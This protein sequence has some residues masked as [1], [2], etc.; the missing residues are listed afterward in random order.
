LSAV[1]LALLIAACSQ[2]PQGVAPPD[3]EPQF[4]TPG[5][6]T[7]FRLAAS[8]E[9]IYVAGGWNDK[10]AL[11]KFTRTGRLPW[12]RTLT[13]SAGDASSYVIDVASGTAG[14][15]YVLYASEREEYNGGED[16]TTIRR[17]YLRKYAPDKRLVWQRQ[18]TSVPAGSRIET[19]TS[20]RSGNLYLALGWTYPEA[21]GELR[22]YSAGGTLL[23]REATADYARD[24]VV[25]S[26]GLVYSLEGDFET[27][28]RSTLTKYSSRGTV[29]WSKTLPVGG[30]HL[31]LGRDFEV[32]VGG[33][34]E[35]EREILLLAKYNSRGVKLWQKVVRKD[36]FVRLGGLG[37]DEQGNVYAAIT[38]REDPYGEDNIYLYKYL[39]TGHRTY[40]RLLN[41]L[42]DRE[43]EPS[44]NDL[45]V[46]NPEEVYLG[47]GSSESDGFLIR[48][49][50]RNG[51][52]TWVR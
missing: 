30:S 36:F 24:L 40:V 16:T 7:A 48:M 14:H 27:F 46:L 41:A 34:V 15:A 23:W 12:I 11:L 38:D 43:G 8:S 5:I 25:S 26:T 35:A 10:A 3:L 50:G 21:A 33:E 19:L 1:L 51:N 22:K 45:V 29:I 44:L 2:T 37:A 13:P 32:Y 42:A 31:S 9:G 4:G 39:P 28:N 49:N 6:D 18:V 52:T 20:D 47:G 17:Y